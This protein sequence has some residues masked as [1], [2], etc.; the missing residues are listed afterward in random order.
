MLLNSI[1]KFTHGIH[2]SFHKILTLPEIVGDMGYNNYLF[3]RT[4]E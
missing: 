2:T 1:A 4:N 3:F